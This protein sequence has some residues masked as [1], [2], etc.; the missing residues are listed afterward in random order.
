MNR[1]GGQI[2]QYQLGGSQRGDWFP[3][4]AD[5]R[6]LRYAL[7]VMWGLLLWGTLSLSHWPWPAEYTICGIWGCG[8]PLEALA[9][10]HGAWV[11]LLLP[12]VWW[13]WTRQTQRKRRM[14][15]RV[16]LCLG[17]TGL[18]AIGLYERS[19]WYLEAG[20]YAR[21]FFLRRW[22]FVVATWTDLPLLQLCLFGLLL[23]W[24]PGEPTRSTD[25]D[26]TPHGAPPE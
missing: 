3:F 17:V 7:L 25:S 20:E 5:G 23:P 2:G 10:C 15:G 11:V 4:S 18:L 13:S 22:A 9:G 1:A 16:L 26:E 6:S 24:L 19:T 21:S 12:V 14:L 8:A